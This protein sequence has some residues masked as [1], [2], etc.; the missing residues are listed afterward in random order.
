MLEATRCGAGASS[1]NGGFLEAT[2]THGLR[3]GLRRFPREIG[4]LEALGQDNLRRSGRMISRAPESTRSSSALGIVAVALEQRHVDEL[5]D[6]AELARPRAR[7][8]AARRARMRALVDSPMYLGGLWRRSGGGARRSGRLVDGLRRAAVAAGVRIHEHSGGSRATSGPAAGRRRAQRP[9]GR[10]RAAGAAAAA[11]DERV[12]A[13]AEGDPA[14][15]RPRVRL[16]ARQR[17]ARRGG[18]AALRWDGRQG[19]VD[20]GNQFHYYRLTP[21]E[22]ILWG[23]YDAVY[24][25]GGPVGPHLDEHDATFAKLSQHFF[26]TF[27]QLEGL[28]FSHRWG[29]AIDTCS[30]FSVF[31]GRAFGGR[32][33]YALGYTGLGIGASRW[34]AR[35]ALDMLDQRTTEATR[36]ALARRR[37]L[38]FPPEPLRSAVIQLT[39]SASS[40]QPTGASG[41]AAGA[42]AATRSTAPRLGFDELMAPCQ[43]SRRTT[44][45]RSTSSTICHSDGARSS[46]QLG[47]HAQRPL[48]AARAAGVVERDHP[49]DPDLRMPDLPVLAASGV[50]VV[51]VDEQEI[52]RAGAPAAPDILAARDVPVHRGTAGPRR[53]SDRKPGRGRVATP[54]EVERRALLVDERV[55]QVE[56][57]LRRHRRAEHD[58]RGSLVDADLDDAAGVELADEPRQQLTLG[59]RMHRA[60]GDQPAAERERPEGGR[61]ADGVRDQAA[62]RLRER[63]GEDDSDAPTRAPAGSGRPGPNCRI[64]VPCHV[65][66]TPRG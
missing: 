29:G 46:E 14:L 55:D 2:L 13:A 22:R 59:G 35:T 10:R 31:F 1:R 66:L 9:H 41:R 16:R 7:G 39:R 63:H 12:S 48:T 60:R 44:T 58:R 27:P 17:A 40:P 25:Y 11:G 28:R 43:A 21:D 51:A 15:H 5:A 24:R 50:A 53:A 23:G 61:L 57:R 36:M 62:D 54:A 32:C 3:N 38:P 52:D 18:D 33:V 6:E 30:R 45:I 20:T 4:Q 8:R 26:T 34:G 19:I 49:A 56:L 65:D 37:P 64:P 42:V 47:D